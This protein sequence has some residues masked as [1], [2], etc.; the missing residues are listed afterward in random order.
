MLAILAEDISDAE[1]L[2]Q[3]VRRRRG[4]DRLPI[5]KKDYEGCAGI[6]RKG[7]RDIRLWVSRGIITEIIICHD[8]DRNP[9]SEIREKVRK[10]VLRRSGFDGPAC[11]AVPVEAIEAW[12]IADETAIHRVIPSIRLKGHVRPETI[13]DPKAWLIRMS[14]R[15]NSKPL[16]VPN[17]SNPVVAKYLRFDVVAKKC[18]S[19]KAFVEWLDNPTPIGT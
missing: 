11:I 1:V 13:P 2:T 9:P 7:Y 17:N 16:Y 14:R 6:C 18:P 5:R 19:F 3:L 8:A 15:R 12:M 4:D 10:A